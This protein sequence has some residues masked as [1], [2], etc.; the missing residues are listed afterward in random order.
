M[1]E[2]FEQITKRNYEKIFRIET[3]IKNIRIFFDFPNFPYTLASNRISPS[4]MIG[5]SLMEN[6]KLG[7]LK[8]P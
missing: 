5:M 3:V 2:L 7:T 6:L 8:T 4:G 1:D